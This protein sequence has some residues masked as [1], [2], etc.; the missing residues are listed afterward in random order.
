MPFYQCPQCKNKWQYPLEKCPD[1]F[2]EVG[3]IASE[4]IEVIGVSKV[5]IPSILHPKV[6]YFVL[7]LEDE[8]GNRWVQ[9]SEKEY[10]IGQQYIL[11]PASDKKAV[12]IERIKYDISEA[13]ERVVYLVGGIKL[14]QNSKILI[15]PTL[16]APKHPHLAE[17]TSPQFLNHTIKYLLKRKVNS[18]N[19]KIAGQSFNDFPLEASMKKSKL[20]SVCQENKVIPL[21]LSKKGFLKK[22]GGRFSFFVSKETLKA[23]IIIN[24]PILKLDAQLKIKGAAYNALKLLKKESFSLLLPQLQELLKEF[25]KE[26]PQIL[27]IAE[28]NVIQRKN[29]QTVFLGLVLASF[30]PLNLDRVSAEIAMETDLPEYLKNIKIEGV[31]IAGRKIKEVQYR[32][33]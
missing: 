12:A 29:K 6:P 20:W 2:L 21:D 8:K 27:T 30:N 4:K 13:I 17:N 33:S 1:C 11:R 23:D 26:L 7:V 10:Q 9:K 16:V 18:A 3:K 25:P 32:I 22:G 24:L 31:T 19:I 14:D 15:L 28:A 5:N